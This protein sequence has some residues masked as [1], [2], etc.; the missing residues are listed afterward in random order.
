MKRRPLS[1]VPS[2]QL[3]VSAGVGASLGAVIEM[4]S[5]AYGLPLPPGSGAAL[6]AA[7]TGLV[8]YLQGHGRKLAAPE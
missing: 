2:P 1:R 5:A 6:A 8:H 4:A 3:G 7:A